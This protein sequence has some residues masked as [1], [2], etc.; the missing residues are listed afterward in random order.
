MDKKNIIKIFISFFF[1]FV[2]LTNTSLY[3]F[4]LHVNSENS[5]EISEPLSSGDSCDIVI[6]DVI[7][8][9]TIKI[10]VVNQIF[11]YIPTLSKQINTT[12][13][14]PPKFWV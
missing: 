14:Q 4:S 11:T 3:T 9:Y 8:K 2:F 13:F 7:C 12:I 5:I 6:P 1:M 10:I